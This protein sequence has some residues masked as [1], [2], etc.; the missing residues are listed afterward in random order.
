MKRPLHTL[1]AIFIAL[2]FAFPLKLLAT[3]VWFSNS[4]NLGGEWNEPTTWRNI[5]DGEPGIPQPGD[6]IIIN[7]GDEVIISST[8][9]LTTIH[10]NKPTNILVNG[11]LT[12]WSFGNCAVVSCDIDLLLDA[13][14]TINVP[15]AVTS[16]IGIHGGGPEPEQKDIWIGGVSVL[17]TNEWPFGPGI[18]PMEFAL[19]VRLASFSGIALESSVVLKWHTESEE[20]TR[21]FLLQR[22]AT[23]MNDFET[24]GTV[25]ATGFSEID[26]HYSFEDRAPLALG[27]YRLKVIDFDGTFD[28]SNIIAVEKYHTGATDVQVFPVPIQNE[29]NVWLRSDKKNEA[30]LKLI[31]NLGQLILTERLMLDEGENRFNFIWEKPGQGVHFIIIENDQ[32]RIVKKVF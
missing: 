9:D 17:P 15:N 16:S 7:G 31:N 1:I 25:A 12:F 23:G 5:L 30:V 29:V 27:Y 6:L 10:N 3:G 20:N 14:S 4:E 22:S 11:K 21:E 26:N 28:Y 18:L 2:I 24:I 8:V 13:G 32:E 19:P